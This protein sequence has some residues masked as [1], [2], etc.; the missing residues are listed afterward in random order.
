M[1]QKKMK[2]QATQWENIHNH[3]YDKGFVSIM[4][5]NLLKSIN[6]K[7]NNPSAK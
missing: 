4:C 1:K 3:I 6:N 2:Q 5:K 7:T